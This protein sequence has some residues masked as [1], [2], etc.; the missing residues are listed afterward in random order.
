MFKHPVK[1]FLKQVDLIW[2]LEL[3][4]LHDFAFSKTVGTDWDAKIW[5]L[6]TKRE[7]R[8]ILKKQMLLF[9]LFKPTDSVWCCH[10]GMAT[11]K[12]GGEMAGSG[13]SLGIS[14]DGCKFSF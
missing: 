5:K 3:T 12:E 1:W 14:I 4:T 7:I 11:V 13:V 6:K 2:S 9:S 10:K 8:C